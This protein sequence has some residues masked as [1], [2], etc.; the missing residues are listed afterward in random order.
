M[1]SA[2]LVLESPTSTKGILRYLQLAHE[3]KEYS[4]TGLHEQI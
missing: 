1:E 3:N 4:K 2:Y